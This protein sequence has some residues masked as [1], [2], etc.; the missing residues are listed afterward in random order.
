LNNSRPVAAAKLERGKSPQLNQ[1]SF[2]GIGRR[3]AREADVFHQLFRVV[4]FWW[5]NPVGF[6][7]QLDERPR[8]C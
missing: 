5:P 2:V 3:A 8:D 6:G 7:A 4:H 1:P